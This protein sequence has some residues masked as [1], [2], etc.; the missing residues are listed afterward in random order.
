MGVLTH[1]EQLHPAFAG[2]V[3]TRPAWGSPGPFGAFSAEQF[4]GATALHHR[5]GSMIP[6]RMI[7]CG[8]WSPCRP[9]PHVRHHY[10][11]QLAAVTHPPGDNRHLGYPAQLLV[12]RMH[13]M[14]ET[15]VPGTST[16]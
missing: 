4:G 7:A 1:I 11:R 14:S 8:R 10:R 16:H 2:K 15:A 3:S 6:T 9:R 12:W 5:L 13:L